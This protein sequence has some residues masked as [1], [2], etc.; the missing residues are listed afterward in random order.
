MKKLILL[1]I[2]S[3][4]SSINLFS[5]TYTVRGIDI[6]DL[7]V[8]YVQIRA[9]NKPMS[10]D[11]WNLVV[12]L[13][14]PNTAWNWNQMQLKKNGEEIKMDSPM[15]LI[16]IFAKSG[17]E[18]VEFASMTSQN[19]LFYVMRNEKYSIKKPVELSE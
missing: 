10:I 15:N 18:L 3:V 14:K 2:I 4:L 16:N 11:K 19:A 5:Q 8:E 7:G 17:Y 6:K 13:G 12:D 1:S 9:T